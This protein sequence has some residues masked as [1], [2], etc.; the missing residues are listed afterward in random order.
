VVAITEVLSLVWDLNHFG[1]K[2]RHTEMS[3]LDLVV[4]NLRPFV[5][6]ACTFTPGPHFGP[7]YNNF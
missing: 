6:K 4:P 7:I 1:G 3:A 2:G 5:Q